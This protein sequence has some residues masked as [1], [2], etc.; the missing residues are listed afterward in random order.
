MTPN[1][2]I[3]DEF[4]KPRPPFTASPE[5]PEPTAHIPAKDRPY[6][7]LVHFNH[8]GPRTHSDVRGKK[9]F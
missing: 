2:F 4:I 7:P 6:A 9:E 3:A 5:K 1:D 8:Y